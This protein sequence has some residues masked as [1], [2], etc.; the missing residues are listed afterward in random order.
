M[1]R[2]TKLQRAAKQGDLATV[3]ALLAKGADVDGRNECGETALHF[4]ARMGHEDVIDYLVEAG[5]NPFPKDLQG[6]IPPDARKYLARSLV[7]FRGQI[8]EH[9]YQRKLKE[10]EYDYQ[11]QR[12]AV[13]KDML[14]RLG[15][16]IPETMEEREE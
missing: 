6:R 14:D 4:A 15:L 9:G 7:K 1:T 11:K 2:I 5:A 16:T 10:I 3:R 12:A 13:L 8:E